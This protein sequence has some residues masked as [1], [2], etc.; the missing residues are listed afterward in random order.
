MTPER[1]AGLV[2][3]WVRAYT[4]GLPTPIA[5]RRVEEIDADLHDH[6]A[7]ERAH[8]T[9]DRRIAL[10]IL[11]RMVRGLRA[12]ASWRG[13][14]A[15]AMA[16]RS[17]AEGAIEPSRAALRSALRVARATAVILLLPLLAMQITDEMAWTPFDFAVAG[18]LLGGTG[19]LYELLTR[20]AG[21]VEYRAAAAVALMAVFIL[22][23]LVGAVGVIGEDGDRADLL[24]GGVL[25]VGIIGALLARFRANGMARALLAT[26]LAQ[27]LVAVIA[28]IAGKHQAPIS[29]VFELLGLNGFFIALFIASAWLFRR[30]ARK[31][32]TVDRAPVTR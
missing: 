5:R 28:L 1:V 16:H 23:W 13:R 29:S 19:L 27:A 12:D 14:Q 21:N 30:A 15:E 2:R 32:E 7:H 24:Y 3:A 4:R 26:A 11:S 6:I 22:V 25:A 8:G 20:K 17:T 9:G 31:Q 10:G 18:A